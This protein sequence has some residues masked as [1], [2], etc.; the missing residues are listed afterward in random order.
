MAYQYIYY[1]HR[2]ELS[3]KGVAELAPKLWL[4]ENGS[5]AA[6][7]ST[8]AARRG[9]LSAYPHGSELAVAFVRADFQ[10]QPPYTACYAGVH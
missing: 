1:Y 9:R 6:R 8:A 10:T 4:V 2:Q 5:R 3:A 7:R